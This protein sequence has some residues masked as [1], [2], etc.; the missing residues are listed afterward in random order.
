M[1]QFVAR[2][3]CLWESGQERLPLGGDLRPSLVRRIGH[4]LGVAP[5]RQ[6]VL[7]ECFPDYGISGQTVLLFPGII[8][9]A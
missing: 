6:P 3:L 1:Y 2:L 7:L 8:D 9:S 5:F 4:A